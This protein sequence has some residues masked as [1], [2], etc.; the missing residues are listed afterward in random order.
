MDDKSEGEY[1]Q[2][3]L[4]SAY[5]DNQQHSAL[6]MQDVNKVLKAIAAA[7]GSVVE[8]NIEHASGHFIVSIVYTLPE[9]ATLSEA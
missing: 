2:V 6:L 8:R 7:G 4:D 9:G 1:L 3:Y 5:I